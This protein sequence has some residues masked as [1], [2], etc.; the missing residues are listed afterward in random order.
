M[1]SRGSQHP[2][3][4]GFW[5]LTVTV[6]RKNPR[7]LEV[8]YSSTNSPISLARRRTLVSILRYS[9]TPLICTQ[10]GTSSIW[11]SSSASS[12]GHLLT[13]KF[14]FMTSQGTCSRIFTAVLSSCA[15]MM[16]VVYRN[17]FTSISPISF[18]EDLR[19][20]LTPHLFKVRWD[21]AAPTNLTPCSMVPR[22]IDFSRCTT[23]SSTSG[24]AMC[25]LI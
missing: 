11:I 22:F 23:N 4:N 15:V 18:H 6:T 2:V 21:K 13:E 5:V 25:A 14:Y 3:V 12:G 1:S 10:K 7:A 17:H 16:N 20:F 19:I 24:C 8:T 9:G